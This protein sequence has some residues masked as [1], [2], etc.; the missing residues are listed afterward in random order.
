[1]NADKENRIFVATFEPITYNIYRFL[2]MCDELEITNAMNQHEVYDCV[3][4][5]LGIHGKQYLLNR[6]QLQI[7]YHPMQIGKIK[8]R[9]Y[10][11]PTKE[12]TRIGN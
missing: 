11:V 4:I 12:E 6:D 7:I 5:L 9:S 2:F 3:I 8:I 10:I 1:M